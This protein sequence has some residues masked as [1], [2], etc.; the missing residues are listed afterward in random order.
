[1]LSLVFT[2]FVVSKRQGVQMM[3]MNRYIIECCGLVGAR[4]RVRW[5]TLLNTS[6]NELLDTGRGGFERCADV[7]EY[8]Q[9]TVCGVVVGVYQGY[10]DYLELSFAEYSRHADLIHRC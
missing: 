8:T 10:Q 3:M 9:S 5:N 7:A 2:L 6:L 4:R 1:M